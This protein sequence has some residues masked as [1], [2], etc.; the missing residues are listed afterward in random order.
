MMR[1]IF[2]IPA[3]NSW[4]IG[5]MLN[6]VL[7]MTLASYGAMLSHLPGHLEAMEQIR[8]AELTLEIT[9]HGH[10]HDDSEFEEQHVGHV[11]GHNAADHSHETPHVP[12]LTSLF[13]NISPDT[14]L[15]YATLRPDLNVRDP[16]ERP[17]RPIS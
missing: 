8:H 11:H 13:W 1:Q 5:L 3:R 17:P 10:S 15:V 16:L 14:H 12:P 9:E 6:L 4:V 7:S 2:K